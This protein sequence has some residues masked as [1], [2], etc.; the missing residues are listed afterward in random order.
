MSGDINQI[1]ATNWRKIGQYSPDLA[2]VIE[3]RCR[4]SNG[5]SFKKM[6]QNTRK[7][8]YTFIHH[9]GYGSTNI[10]HGSGKPGDGM[11]PKT[12]AALKVMALAL[13]NFNPPF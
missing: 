6:E 13:P 5:S 1:A 10:G 8:I 11:H 2:E 12:R 4:S 9:V 7:N 3:K